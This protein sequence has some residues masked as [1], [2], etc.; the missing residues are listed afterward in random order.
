[1]ILAGGCF[2]GIEDLIKKLPGVISTEVGYTG[3]YIQNPTYEVV[4]KNQ[5]GHAEAVKIIFDPNKT[6]YEEILT[7]F[8]K[9]HDPT[10]VNRQG[11]D[12][13]S[14]YRSS[15]FYHDEELFKIAKKI[16]K[17]INESHVWN[18]EV[19]TTVEKLKKFYPAEEYHQKYLQKHPDASTCHFERKLSF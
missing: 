7:Y 6:S 13:G 3:G 15:I 17:K 18:R 1:M 4:K 16:I 5:S 14:Q 8:F 11:N 10:T 12:I 2:W 9:I 19:V